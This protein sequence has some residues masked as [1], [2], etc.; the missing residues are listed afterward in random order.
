MTIAKPRPV[1]PT[2]RLIA[3]HAAA[4]IP[5]GAALQTGIGGIPRGRV[6]EIFGPESSGKTTLTLHV[7]ANAQKDGGLAAFVDAEHAL[8]VGYAAKLGV[9]VEKDFEP[10]YVTIRGKGKILQELARI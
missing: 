4:F 10:K 2:A 5:D 8:D 9:D 7:I 1:P 6:T 3:A